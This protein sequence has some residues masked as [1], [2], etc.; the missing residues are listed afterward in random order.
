LD[1]GE[2]FGEGMCLMFVDNADG[3]DDDDREAEA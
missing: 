2:S 1:D 3:V